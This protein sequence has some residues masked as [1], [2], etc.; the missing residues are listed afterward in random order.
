M[1]RQDWDRIGT[2]FYEALERS[3]AEREEFLAGLGDE[4]LVEELRSLLSAHERRG[5][6]DELA[7]GLSGPEVRGLL[8]LGP[9]DPLGPYRI[10][11][12]IAGG[13]TATVY[14]ARDLK[15]ERE[16]AI[17]VLRPELAAVLGA[18]RFVQE[19]KTTAQLQHPHILPLYDSGRSDGFLYYVMP[20]IEGES[21]RDKLNR[22][23][24]LGIEEAVR[25]TTEVADALGHAHRHGIVHRDIKP[26]NIL[27][28]EG[29]ALVADFGIA[30]AVSAASGGRMTETGLSP[31]TPHYMSP[32]QATAEKELT[33]RTD[34]YSL[35]C[36]LY[37]MLMGE[38]PHTGASALQI[39]RKIVTEEV[40]PVTDLRKAVPPNVATAT[41]KALEKV[42]ADRFETA[43]AF[44]EALADVT[45][46]SRSTAASP[47]QVDSVPGRGPSWKLV[48]AAV[49]LALVAGASAVWILR[50]IPD[51]PEIPRGPVRLSIESDSA[52]R[53]LP[54]GSVALSPD[55]S[56]LVYAAQTGSGSML[57]RRRLD[58]LEAHPIPGTEGGF[59]PFFSPD[60]AHLGF[61][62]EDALRRVR[63]D[64]G[65]PHTI[66]EFDGEL[67]GADWG[68][69]DEIV[70]STFRRF[71]A[72]AGRRNHVYTVSADGGAPESLEVLDRLTDSLEISTP[73]FIPGARAL[74]FTGEGWG[75]AQRVGVVSL[76]SGDVRLLVPGVALRYVRSGH[77]VYV[78][79][80]GTLIAQPFDVAKLDTAG[81][82][83]RV[84]DG[85]GLSLMAPPTVA[86]SSSGTLA[87][88]LAHEAFGLVLVDR[89]G[90]QQ[91]LLR[92]R[93]FW[94]PRFSPDGT[95]IAF[96]E[97]AVAGEDIRIHDLA[98][99]TTSRLT[100]DGQLN[101]DP[102][103]NPDG[104][105]LA[106]SRRAPSGKELYVVSAE[107]GD[108]DPVL[109]QDGGQ[110]AT[111]W[112]P[113]GSYLVFT[114]HEGFPLNR[115][116]WIVAPSEDG[117]PRP[118]LATPFQEDAGRVSPSGRWLAYQ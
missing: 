52:H 70:F 2:L 33:H 97:I 115:D 21:L 3:G 118:F 22:E 101:N 84:V 87:Y 88:T 68:A 8:R 98:V 113:D 82:A 6:F 112:S 114:N 54:F 56:V 62:T 106:F 15:L 61:R 66:T 102:V 109:V 57:Y 77:L 49:G 91:I 117:E 36:V 11:R 46:A 80:D 90:N 20:Y 16:V 75:P 51:S 38:P 76:E 9:G 47:A 94:V 110:Y 108:P 4:S 96:G 67:W 13:G 17:K 111:D 116:I 107:G 1:N 72:E 86:V 39:M 44:A 48:S 55:G 79:P 105:S 100:F 40:R 95:R 89:D 35:G 85:L 43:E 45:F 93:R 37:E 63:L 12:E 59:Q 5:A 60:G 10:V 23:T 31:G 81:P 50:P 64:G 53:I 42:P 7:E 34:I 65:E 78:Q 69:D 83:R 74:L 73:A 99:G 27:L 14:E 18:D 28:Q 19:M 26:E 41:A 103:W 71:G 104:T 92:G 30:L 58:E 25:I 29:R 32:E 24:Q